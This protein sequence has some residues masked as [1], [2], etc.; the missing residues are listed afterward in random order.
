MEE[1]LMFGLGKLEKYLEPAVTLIEIIRQIY[2]DTG[3]KN[4]LETTGKTS[5][6][7]VKYRNY[8]LFA[9]IELDKD[10]TEETS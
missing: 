10:Y 3:M 6:I 7:M 5:V 8:K 4:E 1:T 2:H 9:Q